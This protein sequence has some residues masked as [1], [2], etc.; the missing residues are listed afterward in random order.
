MELLSGFEGTGEARPSLILNLT[1]LRSVVLAVDRGESIFMW[2]SGPNVMCSRISCLALEP[3]IFL[4]FFNK[5][6]KWD[7]RGLRSSVIPRKVD[8]IKDTLRRRKDGARKTGQAS[9]LEVQQVE[10]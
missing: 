3:W 2:L 6:G 4:F 5:R 8:R 10:G 9:D 7:C 1:P